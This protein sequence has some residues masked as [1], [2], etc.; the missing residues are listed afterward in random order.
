MIVLT[1]ITV[2]FM[3]AGII[4]GTM[5]INVQVPWQFDK[6]E[7][8][9]PWYSLVFVSVILMALITIVF[10]RMKIFKLR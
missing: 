1:F 9:Y 5:G 2:V 3:P 8:L 7:S 6:L 10:A 4:G